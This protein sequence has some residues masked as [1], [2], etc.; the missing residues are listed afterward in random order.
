MA[1]WIKRAKSKKDFEEITRIHCIMF[2]GGL[3]EVPEFKGVWW[4][5]YWEKKA[6]GFCGVH[7]SRYYA[8][9]AYLCR[10]AVFY[11]HSGRQLQ[12]KLIRV[13]ERWAR[14][15]GMDW[16]VTDTGTPNYA[17]SNSMIACGYKLWNPPR[18]TRWAFY[19][20]PLYWHKK[21]SPES[22]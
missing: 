16:M 20:K 9:T 13:R 21:L 15:Q 2:Q 18:E 6:I 12:R 1:Y 4:L 22:E 17:S 3:E 5:L 7:L 10:V 8:K 14:A 11:S 19:P